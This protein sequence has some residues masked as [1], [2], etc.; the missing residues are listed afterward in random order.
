MARFRAPSS[1]SEDEPISSPEKQPLKGKGKAVLRYPSSDD[2]EESDQ[3]GED[4]YAEVE[5]ASE[6]DDDDDDEEEEEDADDEDDDSESEDQQ[7]RSDPSILP[8]AREVGVLPQRMHVMQST[9]F[10]QPEEAAALRDVKLGPGHRRVP[11]LSRKHSRD[12]EGDGL[13][14]D[15]RP[16]CPFHRSDRKELSLIR[17]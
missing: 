3:E 9:L 2:S 12:S 6:E 15:S 4:I 5:R 7:H 13:R 1:D 17:A 8:W 11:E 14:A 16:V 10:R